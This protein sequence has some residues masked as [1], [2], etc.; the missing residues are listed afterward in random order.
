MNRL[1]T[2]P[3][4]REQARRALLLLGVPAPARLVVDVHEALFDG[5]LDMPAVVALLRDDQRGVQRLTSD[6]ADDDDADDDDADDGGGVVVGGRERTSPGAAPLS[7]YLFC[8]GLNADLTAARGLV[9]LAEWPLIRRIVTPAA[10]RADALAAVLR[11]AEFVAMQ[12][13]LGRCP[14]L[15]LRR[16]AAGVPGGLEATD[17][18]DAARAALADPDLVAA[19]AVEA[20]RREAAAVRA[21]RLDAARQLFGVAAVPRQ[22]GGA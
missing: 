16:L 7:A 10:A 12:P 21:A 6:D 2:L 3:S 19:V 17:V 14:N 13:G 5:D 9:A 1:S 22:R 18:G 4:T 11:V 15:L 20:A 8:R